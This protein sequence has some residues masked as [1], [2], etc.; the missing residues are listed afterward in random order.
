MLQELHEALPTC[1]FNIV[2]ASAIPSHCPSGSF[3]WAGYHTSIKDLCKQWVCVRPALSER[4]RMVSQGHPPGLQREG[5][6]SWE[7]PH[8]DPATQPSPWAATCLALF[9]WWGVLTGTSPENSRES[10][11]HFS[12]PRRASFPKN[13]DSCLGKMKCRVCLYVLQ[14]NRGFEM[15]YLICS[16]DRLSGLEP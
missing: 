2:T 10:G 15:T 3:W 5:A 12:D 13:P 14:G 4:R 8:H 7:H 9:R 1:Y 11:P 6:G 16:S